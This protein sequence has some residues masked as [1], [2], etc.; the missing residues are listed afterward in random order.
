MLGNGSASP[1]PLAN[2]TTLPIKPSVHSTRPLLSSHALHL[3]TSLP[4]AFCE[5]APQTLLISSLVRMPLI[6]YFPARIRWRLSL[7]KH[8]TSASTRLRPWVTSTSLSA[9]GISQR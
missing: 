3:L 6:Q 9:R 8:A 4:H 1:Y 2:P 7:E 5:N